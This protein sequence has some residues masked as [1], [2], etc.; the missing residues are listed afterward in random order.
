MIKTKCFFILAAMLLSIGAFAQSNGTL[1]GDLNEDG[2]VDIADLTILVNIILNKQTPQQTYYWYV[3]KNESLLGK[4]G[5]SYDLNLDNLESYKVNSINDI[6]T[7]SQSVEDIE[8]NIYIV[9]PTEWVNQFE[10][11]DLNDTHISITDKTSQITSGV[12]GYSILRGNGKIGDTVI[13]VIR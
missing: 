2:K 7:D 11:V 13:K 6:Y 10:I 8:N 9:C 1:K 5:T 3:G 12:T 4:N